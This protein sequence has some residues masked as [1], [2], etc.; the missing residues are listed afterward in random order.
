VP[1]NKSLRGP[2]SIKYSAAGRG[3]GLLEQVLRARV[4]ASRRPTP[5][6]SR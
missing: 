3:G 6:L 1:P 5:E 4:L 2:G